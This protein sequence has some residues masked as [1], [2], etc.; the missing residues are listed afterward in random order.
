ML[1]FFGPDHL[2]GFREVGS[3][4]DLTYSRYRGASRYRL[5][6][7]GNEPSPSFTGDLW[8][9]PIAT[10]F[11]S[12]KRTTASHAICISIHQQQYHAIRKGLHMPCMTPIL[13]DVVRIGRCLHLPWQRQNT[14]FLHNH[15][16]TNTTCAVGLLMP[17]TF[18]IASP[19]HRKVVRLN[20]ASETCFRWAAN[21]YK[22]MLMTRILHLKYL[23]QRFIQLLP[24]SYIK[25][26]PQRHIHLDF[27]YANPKRHAHRK[28]SS[29]FTER[30]GRP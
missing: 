25:N 22:P 5:L 10:L 14:I 18:T 24:R 4:S 9:S 3:D 28:Q 30:Q 17:F 29:S 7:S 1:V 20:T 11:S 23:G 19:L 6:L 12:F 13:R 27:L 8:G 16:Y 15:I 26:N 21:P 2:P